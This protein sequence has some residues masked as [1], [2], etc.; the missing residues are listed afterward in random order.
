M[1]IFFLTFVCRF[2]RK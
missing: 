2:Q 1:N